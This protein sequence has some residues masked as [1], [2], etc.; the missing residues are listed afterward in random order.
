MKRLITALVVVLPIYAAT[1]THANAP[2]QGTMA[3][4]V[5]E[6]EKDK[7]K[8]VS[9]KDVEP[10]QIVEYQL[11]YTN[12]GDSAISG[13]KVV[14]PVPD[15]TVYL[16]NSAIAEQVASLQVSIDGG[17]TFEPE[18]VKRTIVKENGEIVEQ[19]IPPEKYTHIQWVPA[20]AIEGDGGKQ[21]YSYRVRVK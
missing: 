3:A 12:Q 16:S 13:L 8:L 21:F 11:T 7:E 5:V 10:N 18:P 4:F 14:G 17:E 6:I 2:V 19:I 20:N 9:A 1:A 15:G